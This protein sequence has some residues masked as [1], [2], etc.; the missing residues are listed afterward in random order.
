VRA[1]KNGGGVRDPEALVLA[2][3]HSRKGVSIPSVDRDLRNRC[4]YGGGGKITKAEWW[5]LILH[6]N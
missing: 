1:R 3:M 4:S 5:V 6:I 2:V